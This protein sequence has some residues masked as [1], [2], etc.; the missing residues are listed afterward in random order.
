MW[1][2]RCLANENLPAPAIR[3]LRTTGLEVAAIREES[4]G[5]DDEQ[6]LAR[7]VNEQRWLLTFD[8]DYGELIYRRGLAAP[9]ALVLF[10]L[11]RFAPEEPAHRLLALLAS[12]EARDGGYFI[13]LDE[14]VRWRPFGDASGGR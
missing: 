11:G 7:A 14:A 1:P 13:V 3:R 6:V 12:P 4:P 9:P 2:P 8:M 5:I 10:R